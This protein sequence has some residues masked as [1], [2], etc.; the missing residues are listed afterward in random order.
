M[1]EEKRAH[2]R[3]VVRYRVEIRLGASNPIPGRVENLGTLGAFVTT[4]ELEPH[5]EVG[6]LVELVIWVP[7][8]E[9]FTVAGQVLRLDQEF[10]EGDIRR[11]FAV[12]FAHGVEV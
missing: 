5:I 1:G 3:L 11:A 8:K 9:P 7:E 10:A 12:K 6:D 4:L 2:E